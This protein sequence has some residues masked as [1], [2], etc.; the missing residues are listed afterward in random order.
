MN[1]MMTSMVREIVDTNKMQHIMVICVEIH[2]KN[3]TSHASPGALNL[4]G[5]LI[6][7]FIMFWPARIFI[8]IW[9]CIR[10]AQINRTPKTLGWGGT[11]RTIVPKANLIQNIKTIWVI[12]TKITSLKFVK[13]T[14]SVYCKP[15][16]YLFFWVFSTQCIVNMQRSEALSISIIST[17]EFVFVFLNCLHHV[18]KFLESFILYLELFR[19][20]SEKITH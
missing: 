18:V 17:K 14:C 15:I 8:S 6:A 7:Y 2:C 4:C 9:R 3:P 11:T 10:R 16:F 12:N 20:P 19:I 13:A 5:W 1:L